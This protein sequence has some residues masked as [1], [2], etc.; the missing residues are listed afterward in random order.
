MLG[1]LGILCAIF[2][3]V[4]SVGWGGA[5]LLLPTTLRSHQLWLAPW[6]GLLIIDISG[7]LLSRIGLGTNSSIYWI[8][9]LGICLTTVAWRQNKLFVPSWRTIDFYILMAMLASLLLS[10]S[11]L[12]FYIH[13]P[14]TFTLGNNDAQNSAVIGDY[15]QNYSLRQVYP[16]VPHNQID[17]TTPANVQLINAYALVR[18]GAWIIYGLFG[19]LVHAQT[20]QVFSISLAVF[21]AY[22]TALVGV[23]SW[24]F[25]GRLFVVAIAL[26]ISSLNPTLL[27]FVYQGFGAHIPMQGMVMFGFLLLSE[28]QGFEKINIL[29]LSMVGSTLLTNYPE[30]SLFFF[31]PTLVYIILRIIL[32]Q[33]RL[34]WTRTVLLASLFTF[35]IDPR[36]MIDGVK[37]FFETYKNPHGWPH[38][39]SSLL[40]MLGITP[41]YVLQQS[42][43]TQAL[44][45]LSI[46]TL[47]II[48]FGLINLRKRMLSIS[49]FALFSFSLV[50]L[51][52]FKEDS[53]GYHKA[54]GFTMF[55]FAISLAS[56]IDVLIKNISYSA[57]KLKYVRASILIALTILMFMSLKSM[58]DLFF[59][60]GDRLRYVNSDLEDISHIPKELIDG[61]RIYINEADVWNQLWI[62]TFL[63]NRDIT[64]MIHNPLYG[65]TWLSDHVAEPSL[66][67]DANPSG[68]IH[69]A[70]SAP[71]K[72]LWGNSR[73]RL[74]TL[75][76]RDIS[77]KGDRGVSCPSIPTAPICNV[78]NDATFLINFY[79][80]NT[81]NLAN[82]TFYFQINPDIPKI[83]F[84]LN[85]ELLVADSVTPTTRK[86]PQSYSIK[87][88][89]KKNSNQLRLHFSESSMKGSKNHF[90]GT[91]ILQSLNVERQK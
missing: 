34:A 17:A 59:M 65:D 1:I 78:E 4:W 29:L 53:Y 16:P 91:V 6:I 45:Y 31:A 49:I 63:E 76:P 61:K 72:V 62:V 43:L 68:V 40:D 27:Y 89:L 32:G 19:S 9:L 84:Y 71:F 64:F 18:P 69:Y 56:G 21:Q 7:I 85:D 22:Y 23:F 15:L 5:C 87:V 42:S 44:S 67:L 39:F 11:P 90:P 82:L 86:I 52:F 79:G 66:L 10:L 13:S 80:K 3:F 47:G 12:I 54:S 77:V 8:I 70:D 73:Y 30:V 55:I 41:A 58:N 74:R 14:T 26:A 57:R 51:R 24:V 37:F 20:H 28:I 35:L 36:G 88:N 25:T 75:E 33:Q 81:G 38:P 46:P 48:C 2:A 50:Y 83:N 60:K